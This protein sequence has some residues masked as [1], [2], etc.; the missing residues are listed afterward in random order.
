MLRGEFPVLQ[1]FFAGSLL[2]F[3]LGQVFVF[4]TPRILILEKIVSRPA[5]RDTLD[6]DEKLRRDPFDRSKPVFEFAIL[7]LR[8]QR[9]PKPV[10][11]ALTQSYALAQTGDSIPFEQGIA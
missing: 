11:K 8:I 6:R 5:E 3:G 7:N 10:Q 1:G 9:V 4:D 2:V